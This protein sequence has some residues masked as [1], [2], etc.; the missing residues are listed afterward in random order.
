M[1]QKYDLDWSGANVEMANLILRQGELY[2]NAQFQAALAADQRAM[3]SASLL[4][5]FAAVV[6]GGTIAYYE[7]TEG[8]AELYAGLVVVLFMSTGAFL[9]MHSARPVKFASVGAE[10]KVWWSLRG[11][12]VLSAIGGEAENYQERIEY[13]ESVLRKN[14]SF[15][16]WGARLAWAG[17]IAGLFVWGVTRYLTNLKTC[18]S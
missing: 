5:G 17:P 2:L 7:Q 16:I 9:S 18:L 1:G 6:F 15:Y 3:V 12:T 14:A 13:N 11:G 4:S 8:V 10:P